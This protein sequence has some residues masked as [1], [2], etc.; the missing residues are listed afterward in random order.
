MLFHKLSTTGS[1]QGAL[2]NADGFVCQ[3]MPDNLEVCKNN[4]RI[5]GLVVDRQNVGVAFSGID[6]FQLAVV[7]ISN[8][9]RHG[10]SVET[11]WKFGEDQNGEQE[12]KATVAVGSEFLVDLKCTAG[13]VDPL[14]QG[15]TLRGTNLVISVKPAN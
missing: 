6:P 1:F 14:F 10:Y 8:Y 7:S 2:E 12:G 5:I 3:M 15:K 9:F 13:D 11:D 4:S